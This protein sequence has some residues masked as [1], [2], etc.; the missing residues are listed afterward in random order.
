MK[1]IMIGLLI[2]L[3]SLT[4]QAH[5]FSKEEY[6]LRTSIRVSD[7]G[8][9]PLV[10]LEIPIP[11]A[12]KEINAKAED[13]TEKKKKKIEKYNKKQWKLL[14]KN[15]SFSIDG[16][17][18][19]G[20]WLPIK[21][22]ANGK[23]A[24]GFFVYLVSFQH[25]SRTPLQNGSTI[26]IENRAYLDAPMVYSGAAKASAPWSITESTSKNVLGENEMAELSDPKRW[27]SDAKLRKM[28]VVVGK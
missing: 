21:H 8:V 11:I 19:K 15:L 14:A 4:A 10:A 22:K 12:L 27:S 28:K 16:K 24:E 26:I 6:S 20:K 18:A 13:S 9:V 1:K 23:A 5:P 2:G 3:W 25:K 7:K 17:K